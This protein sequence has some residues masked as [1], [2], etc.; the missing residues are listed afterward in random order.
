MHRFQARHFATQQPIE[1]SIDNDRISAVRE[2]QLTDEDA[3]QLP[4][5]S[6]GFFDIQIN[7]YG[8]SW[9][10]SGDLTVDQ[11]VE[12]TQSLVDRGIARFFPTLI[13]ASYE[14]LLHGFS[15]LREACQQSD[16]VADC[17]AGYH[18][19]GPYISAE[20]GP[21]GAHPIQH[22]RGAD[23]DEFCR[24]QGASG[25]RI[26]L[27][28]L[29]AE[30]EHAVDFIHQ[31][32][33][34]GV[35]VALGHTGASPA[36]IRAAV[37][38]GAT[39]STHFGNGAHGQLPRHP[40]YLWEQL[41]DDRLWASVIADGWHVPDSVLTC[42]LK[43]KTPQHTVLTCDVSGFA[44]CAPGT[45]QEGDVG[46]EVLD[47]GRLV[48]AGQRQFLAGSGAT[49]GDCVVGMMR[50]CGIS[51]MQAV[52]MVTVNPSTLMQEPLVRIA[53]GEPAT[54]TVFQIV[55]DMSQT[56][57]DSAFQPIATFVD[58]KQR[59]GRAIGTTG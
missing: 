24:L 51:L 22:V 52:D 11:V 35:V 39:L 29:A 5:V 44:G 38:A 18:L 12:I 10:C 57:A 50:S 47:D 32:V 7:G 8:G 33:G 26:R 43:C 4:Y 28:T 23:W 2:L 9:F 14:A 1:V 36:Q 48:V 37:D 45:Y 49:T 56:V 54:L 42:V 25:N 41:A 27:V 58:G 19:E 3:R 53:E 13:T 55:P 17:V 34:S 21:R 30:A 31:C 40:N 59:G 16:L 6:P 20:D 46:V 15:I